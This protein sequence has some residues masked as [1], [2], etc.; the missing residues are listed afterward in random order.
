MVEEKTSRIV[1]ILLTTVRPWQ[2]M[3]GKVLG[4]GL[5]GL[6]QLAVVLVAG[7]ATGSFTFPPAL[8]GT[9]AVWAVVWFLLGFA[10]YALVFA[11]LGAL[12][13]RQQEVGGV[14]APA[15]MLIA[16]PYTVGIFILP[17]DP[18]NEFVALLSLIPLFA[19][20]R[21]QRDRLLVAPVLP[22]TA[23]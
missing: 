18:D 14:T 12:V 8:A 15:M 3:A 13:S 22:P 11:A 19:L 20:S 16:L 7:I 17:A 1:E 5:V 6:A 10:V 9:A 4:I 2:L 23:R 21:F